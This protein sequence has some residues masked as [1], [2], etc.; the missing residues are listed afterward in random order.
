M[1]GKKIGGIG[2]GIVAFV[3]A[4]RLAFNGTSRFFGG[5]TET[6]LQQM[7]AKLNQKL[8]MQVDSATRWDRV[9]AGPGKT[10]S[11]IYTVNIGL[12]ADQKTQLQ[13]SVGQRALASPEMK[14]IFDAGV[15]VWYKY[16]DQSGN[17]VLEFSVRR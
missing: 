2:A 9:E 15:V 11:Y 3:V 10:Y 4:Y 16:L 1:D 6:R 13:N 5:S 12:S 8:P 17:K 14:P 7:A